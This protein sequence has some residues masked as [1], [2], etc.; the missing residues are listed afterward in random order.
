MNGQQQQQPIHSHMANNNKGTTTTH[1]MELYNS[2]VAQLG[3][4]VLSCFMLSSNSV[5]IINDL[6]YKKFHYKISQ[7]LASEYYYNAQ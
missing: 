6:Q 5:R 2:E 1:S 7:S 4:P 3:I